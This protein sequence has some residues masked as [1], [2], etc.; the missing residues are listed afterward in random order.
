MAQPPSRVPSPQLLKAQATRLLLP[1][2]IR[3]TCAARLTRGSVLVSNPAALGASAASGPGLYRP[4]PFIFPGRVP[5]WP[6][7]PGLHIA[8]L[9]HLPLC[10]LH[11]SPS[12]P[13]APTAPLKRSPSKPRK[14]SPPQQG[15][16]PLR[17]PTP[18]IVPSSEDGSEL[19]RPRPRPSPSSSGPSLWASS[20]CISRACSHLS[21]SSRR[22]L[23]PA[24]W[25]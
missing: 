14:S 10:R 18:D 2:L 16:R 11:P 9:S 8:L 12:R 22:P 5:P 19:L 4:Q 17:A 3:G 7:P 20:G 13:H 15:F 23:P 21:E 25:K 1:P 24:A 6:G